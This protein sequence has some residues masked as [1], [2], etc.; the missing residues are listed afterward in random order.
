MSLTRILPIRGTR[1]SFLRLL[2]TLD[3]AER[4]LG[5]AN[6]STSRLF[7]YILV[8][9][10][11]SPIMTKELLKN[12]HKTGYKTRSFAHNLAQWYSWIT[13]YSVSWNQ[14]ILTVYG[15][16][17]FKHNTTALKSKQPRRFRA[18]LVVGRRELSPDWS[19]NGMNSTLPALSNVS[20][21]FAK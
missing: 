9:R 19:L 15:H 20:L 17:L 7:L 21:N 6:C 12:V 18:R 11:V 2:P 16:R 3:T 8:I 5:W 1:L 13:N 4:I 10:V 14:I